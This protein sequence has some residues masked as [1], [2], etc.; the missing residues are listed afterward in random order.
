[1]DKNRGSFVCALIACVFTIG[2]AFYSVLALYPPRALPADAPLDE[3]SAHRAIPHAFA[4]STE[5][6]PTGS[7]NNDAVAAYFLN[8]LR[9][10]GV[11][12][13]FMSKIDVRGNGVE[14][15]QAVIGRIPGAD[16]TG[17]IAISAHYD[18]VPY[19]PGATDD[20]AGCIAMLEVARAFMNRPQLRNDLLFLF[21]DAEEIGA[22]GAHGL[23]H[24]PVTEDIGVIINLEAR[25]TK[26]PAMLFETSSGNS[27]LITELR[28]A[29]A[30]GVLPFT[31][32][33]MFSAYERTPFGTDFTTYRRGGLK[34]YNIA[35]I[36]NFAYYHTMNDSPENIHPPSVQHFGAYLMGLVEHFGDID[37]QQISLENDDAIYFNTLGFNLAQYPM[38]WGTPLALLAALTLLA[39]IVAGRFKRR[40]A[41]LRLLGA[42]LLVPVATLLAVVAALGLQALV[43][44]YANTVHLYTVSFTYIPEPSALYYSNLYCY[45]FGAMAVAI[46]GALFSLA[47]RRLGASEM[48]AA[49]LVWL[50]PALALLVVMFPGGSYLLAWPI[51]FGALGLAVL[52]GGAPEQAPGPGRL[53]LAAAFSVPA[54]FLLTPMWQAL[55]WMLMI[56]GAPLL[57][58]VAILILLN[59][60]PALT[61]VGRAPRLWVLYPALAILALLLIATGMTLT[62]PSKACPL[63]NSVAYYAN[64]DAG[65]AWWLSADED[66]DDWT[67]QF[68]PDGTRMAI[69]DLFRHTSGDHYLRAAAPVA[70]DLTGLQYE[71][72]SDETRDDVRHIT[73]KL[74]TNDAPYSVSM[75]Q[76]GGP[77]ITEATIDAIPLTIRD[78]RLSVYFRLF[79]PEGYELRIETTPG[80]AIAFDVTSTSYGLPEIPGIAPR[81]DHIVPEPNTLRHGLSLR[82]E[83]IHVS[84]SFVIPEAS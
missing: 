72:L 41:P 17:A 2:L 59:L 84:H 63:M 71:I 16:S 11:E 42:L 61:L 4:C 13:E 77:D 66:V 37:F 56:L 9:E 6:H 52:Y 65:D 51:L 80:E 47:S 73:L 26:G 20:I 49:G 44:G 60:M 8:A 27:P 68:F 43:F 19:G 82:G 14:L 81:P 38:S 29:R 48:H 5:P 15:Q 10:M 32:S 31:N 25:G 55:L 22:Y 24:H 70:E 75:R 1:M 83:R 76:T 62:R 35:Y 36:D 54:L 45:A 46:A 69:D 79:A 18:S 7:K 30:H 50:C 39:V 28:K 21:P 33:M 53:L 23:I 64:L 78:D 40:I 67:A 58:I 34:G 12:A 57:T 3:F 74:R